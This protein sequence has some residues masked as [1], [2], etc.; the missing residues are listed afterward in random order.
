MNGSVS[1]LI[2]PEAIEN[3]LRTCCSSEHYSQRKMHIK[4][5]DDAGNPYS[6]EVDVPA[7]ISS[8][9]LLKIRL[10]KFA[11]VSFENE[12]SLNSA[13]KALDKAKKSDDDILSLF[14]TWPRQPTTQPFCAI[15]G[16][17]DIEHHAEEAFYCNSSDKVND[18]L[19]LLGTD[20]LRKLLSDIPADSAA[21]ARYRDMDRLKTIQGLNALRDLLNEAAP[22]D[23]YITSQP[24]S[25]NAAKQTYTILLA[26]LNKYLTRAQWAA[27]ATIAN[28]NCESCTV[29]NDDL[30]KAWGRHYNDGCLDKF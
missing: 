12:E 26:G 21:L 10:E 3:W 17:R 6:H 18:V 9:H 20:A 5:V 30:R 25:F 13:W 29:T 11:K 19:A 1:G 7:K 15:Y 23:K 22:K 14:L 4:L 2:L 8:P 27:L 16:K 24:F 28:A